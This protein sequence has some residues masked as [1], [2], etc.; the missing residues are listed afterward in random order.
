MPTTKAP[1][2][3]T[4]AARQRAEQLGRV[5]DRDLTRI[6]TPRPEPRLRGDQQ[7][8]THLITKAG[9]RRRAALTED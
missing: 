7:L 8:V 9:R 3:N 2:G 1:Q 4:P 6:M 5:I